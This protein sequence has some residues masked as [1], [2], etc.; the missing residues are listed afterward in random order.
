MADPFA[1]I[2]KP[3]P[4]ASIAKPI[5]AGPNMQMTPADLGVTPGLPG[6]RPSALQKTAAIPSRPSTMRDVITGAAKGFANTMF[7]AGV[8]GPTGSYASATNLAYPA[9]GV[10]NP[11]SKVKAPYMNPSSTAQKVGY[12][13]EQALEWLVPSGLEE[14]AGELGARALGKLAPNAPAII[15]KAAP[16]VARIGEQAIES[17]LRNAGQGGDFTTGAVAGGGGALIAPALSKAAQGIAGIAVAPGKTLLKSL[18]EGVE[19]G[20]TVMQE[21]TGVRPSTIAR[22]LGEKISTEDANLSNLLES[23][24]S[25][26]TT[27]SLAPARQ[28]VKG[29]LG[30][31]IAKNAP[32]YIQDV[33]KVGDQLHF[34]YGA[35]GKPIMTSTGSDPWFNPT[36]QP[37]IPLR[38]PE[39]VDPVRAR[40][41]RQGVDLTIGSFNPDA[42]AAI[43]PLQERVRGTIAGG[44]HEAVP[45]SAEPDLRMS[46]LIP[47]R[48]ATWNTA[49]NPS[50]GRAIFNRFARPTGALTG[51]FAGGYEGGKEGGL[52]GVVLGGTAGLAVPELIASPAGQM[53]IARTLASPRSIAVAKGL[54]LQLNRPSVNEKKP[55]E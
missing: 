48:D 15:G 43:A 13:G 9:S 22:Q 44:I 24:K 42:Q 55:T 54:G 2:A 34:Q 27:V 21:S 47:A 52:P 30:S 5:A 50:V 32:A 37:K 6:S 23:A 1:S 19:I 39:T 7:N 14:H 28:I 51:M 45:G 11:A 40:Q 26:G 16:T 41:I 17:G 29:E 38:L 4:F 49:F 20:K 18:P 35:D 31:A 8:A 33:G 36:P 3:D 12:T 25:R 46:N 10:N 53:F